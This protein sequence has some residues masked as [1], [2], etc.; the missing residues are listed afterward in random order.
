MKLEINEI[1]EI[2]KQ[3]NHREKSMKPN[4]GSLKRSTKWDNLALL[5]KK[6]R[7]LTLLKSGIKEETL[8]TTLQKQKG[9]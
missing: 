1:N 8:L 4:T 3:K 9:V 2:R 5:T 6:K 7:G